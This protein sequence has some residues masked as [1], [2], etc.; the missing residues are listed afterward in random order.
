M[1]KIRCCRFIIFFMKI[2]KIKRVNDARI[3]ELE[4][5][6]VTDFD[7]VECPL[8]HRFANKMYIR[9]IFMP[10][11]TLVTSKIHKSQHPYC[12]SKG[13]VSVKIDSGEWVTIEAPFTGI[14]EV[15]T[16]RVLLIHEDCIWTTFHVNKDNCKDISTLENRLLYKYKNK[17]LKN[18][19][20]KT[21][22][23]KKEA[24]L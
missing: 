11:G 3:D 21:I 1:G 18:I 9:E 6:M 5:K 17:L 22:N 10:K 20:T 7:H 19:N 16:R 13:V 15:G 23:F 14:T 2:N 12:V 4:L 8:V 24:I